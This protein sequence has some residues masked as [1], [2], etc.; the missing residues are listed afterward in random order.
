MSPKSPSFRS[1]HRAVW[2]ASTTCAR[3]PI[4][5]LP[6]QL[7]AWRSTRA[8]WIPGPSP[9]SLPNSSEL[10]DLLEQAD[11][12]RI[13]LRRI[14]H[15]GEP[16]TLHVATRYPLDCFRGHALQLVH[17]AIRLTVVSFVKL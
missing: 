1:L 9:K 5:A 4:A 6:P 3:L 11:C 17:E 13:Q 16:E 14:T 10:D 2:A 15:V 8:P 12:P 7:S